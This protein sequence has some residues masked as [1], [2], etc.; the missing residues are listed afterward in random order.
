M[1]TV[2]VHAT[3]AADQSRADSRQRDRI[4]PDLRVREA[5]RPDYDRVDASGDASFPASDPPSW[6]SGG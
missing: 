6:W 5:I 1:T 3:A 2:P 4:E